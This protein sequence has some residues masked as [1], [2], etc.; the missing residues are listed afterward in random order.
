VEIAILPSPAAV[1]AYAARVVARLLREKPEAVL[2]LPTGSTPRPLY[3]ELARLH[4]DE[5]LSFAR[6]TTFNLDE[7]VGVPSDHPGS[8]RRYIVEALV[9]QVDVPAERVHVPDGMAADLPRSCADY[10][11]AI[12]AAGGLDL[13]LLG[14]GEDGHLA[15]NEPTSSLGSRT[16]IKTLS[17]GSRAA[18]QAAFG[19]ADAVPRHVVTIGIATILEARRCLLIATG[20]SKALALA[21]AVEGPLAAMVPA[22]ALQLHPRATA[23]AD[24]AAASGLALADYYRTVYAGKP[25]W[26]RED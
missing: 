9:Q 3:A 25:D 15:F 13:V 8:F 20:A 16:R 14:I 10:E 18:H 17:D 24:E 5:G 26:Q 7:F 2:G 1:G 4:R 12:A 23:L 6:A 21:R 11:A 22:S 19:G